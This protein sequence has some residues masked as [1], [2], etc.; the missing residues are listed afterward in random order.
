MKK[1][2]DFSIYL[3]A[4]RSFL[5]GR[6]LDDVVSA[7]LDGG[8]TIV[9]LREKEAESGEFFETAKK[10]KALLDAS[11]VPLI[12]NDRIDIALAVEASGVHLGQKDLPYHEARRL[13]GPDAIIG[14][15]VENVAQAKQ[16]QTRGADYL[17]AGPVFPTSTKADTGPA[18]GVEGLTDICQAVTIPV[19]AIGGISC[20]NVSTLGGCG[21][22]GIAVVSAIMESSDPRQVAKELKRK[23][24]FTVH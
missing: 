5:K 1:L 23:G 19:V 22:S 20:A 21:I 16:A 7:A 3:V 15:S 14:V 11:G 13:M 2:F 24:Q 8:V 10:L 4:Q 6:E 17:G 9:Q 18:L 12:I